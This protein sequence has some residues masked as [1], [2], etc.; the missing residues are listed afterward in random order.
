[1]QQGKIAA[2]TVRELN[3]ALSV[4]ACIKTWEQHVHEQESAACN[5]R[6]NVNVFV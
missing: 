3:C 4:C 2:E 6:S 5:V 1:M